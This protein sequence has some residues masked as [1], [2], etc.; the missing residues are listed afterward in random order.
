MTDTPRDAFPFEREK[1]TVMDL[2]KFIARSAHFLEPRSSYNGRSWTM[3]ASTTFKRLEHRCNLKT[4]EPEV[5]TEIAAIGAKLHLLDSL[6]AVLTHYDLVGQ[7]IFV[8]ET[9][10]LTGVI[11]WDG[12]G[13]EAFGVVVFALYECFFG[14]MEG[15]HWSPYDFLAGGKYPGQTACQ[16]LEAAFWDTLWEHVGPGMSREDSNEA[17]WVALGAGVVN[18]YFISSMLEEIDLDKGNHARSLNYAKGILLHIRNS[19][20]QS[21]SS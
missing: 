13:I 20:G 3:P 4:L 6:P 9:G 2:G 21:I 8:D 12:A 15:G 17:V 11:D 16:V 10:A 7:N 5:Y 1:K 18:R 14:N 19:R